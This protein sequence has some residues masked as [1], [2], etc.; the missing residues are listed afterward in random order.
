MLPLLPIVLFTFVL[1]SNS[2][3]ISEVTEALRLLDGTA[4]RVVTLQTRLDRMHGA[5]DEL[6][7]SLDDA[8]LMADA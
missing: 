7:A 2:S 8:L 6:I 1:A 4:H 5:L 3:D